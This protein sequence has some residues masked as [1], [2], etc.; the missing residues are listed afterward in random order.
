[1]SVSNSSTLSSLLLP[2]LRR[3][4]GAQPGR[5]GGGRRSGE[6][7]GPAQ[8][9]RSAPRTDP[10]RLRAGRA[11]AQGPQLS[12]A[13]A[14]APA[15]AP[16]SRAHHRL[17]GERQTRRRARGQRHPQARGGLERGT[18]TPAPS[19]TVGLQDGHLVG[20]I[21]HPGSAPPPET[22]GFFHLV[23]LFKGN[24]SGLG[25]QMDPSS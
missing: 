5:G 11:G 23:T 18:Q 12:G 15:P 24:Y 17:D 6:R 25:G 1:V 21:D 20:R 9:P 16:W 13:P 8:P 19:H 22:R 14:P 10:C 2:T 4:P 3:G 7:E